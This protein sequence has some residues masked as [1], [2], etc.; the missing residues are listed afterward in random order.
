MRHRLILWILFTLLLLPGSGQPDENSVSIIISGLYRGRV[1]GCRCQGSYSGGFPR[2]VSSL[3]KEFGTENPAGLD[4]GQILDLD[5]EGGRERSRCAIFGLAKTG[6]KV[7]GVAPRDLFYGV[8]FLQQTADSAGIE[9]V[10]ANLIDAETGQPL[11]KRW[12]LVSVK[13]INLAVTSLV[14]FQPGRR[15][16]API[17]WTTVSPDSV[18]DDLLKLK[19]EEADYSVL[20]TDMA[21][22]DLRVFLTTYPQFDLAFTSSRKVDASSPFKVEKCLI[23]HPEADGRYISWIEIK[24]DSVS[25]HSKPLSVDLHEDSD[26]VDWL[27]KCLGGE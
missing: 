20:L 13:G 1:D 2:Y 8:E 15:Y 19:P 23:A 25:F 24:R 14:N 16:T 3:R 18:I 22:S 27:T 9:I 10:S 11:F 4:C 21:E 17:G 26:A 12:M 7:I 5:F 6:L